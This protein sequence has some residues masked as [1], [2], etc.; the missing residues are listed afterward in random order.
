MCDVFVCCRFCVIQLLSGRK[1]DY[2]KMCVDEYLSSIQRIP[3]HQFIHPS[4]KLTMAKDYRNRR[5]RDK[6]PMGGDTFVHEIK[7]AVESV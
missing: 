4:L 6:G 2:A 7:D 5:G 1:A 3:I